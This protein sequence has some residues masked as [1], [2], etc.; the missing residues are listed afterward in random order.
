M[1]LFDQLRR[2]LFKDTL[3]S[4]SVGAVLGSSAA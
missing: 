4:M 1:I 2:H 3:E